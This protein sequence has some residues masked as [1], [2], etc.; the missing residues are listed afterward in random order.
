MSHPEFTVVLSMHA[1]CWHLSCSHE[2]LACAAGTSAIVPT[3][4]AEK[5]I[6]V[7][8]KGRSNMVTMDLP[9]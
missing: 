3:A 2:A 9:R 7:S 6:V 8:R 1:N 4:N 5:R